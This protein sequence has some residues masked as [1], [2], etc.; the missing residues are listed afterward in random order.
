M[1]GRECQGV[2]CVLAELADAQMG[3]EGGVLGQGRM[4]DWKRQIR[5]FGSCE[6]ERLGQARTGVW[7]SNVTRATAHTPSAHHLAPL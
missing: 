4:G 3:R 1:S 7:G 5:G 2:G 6:D